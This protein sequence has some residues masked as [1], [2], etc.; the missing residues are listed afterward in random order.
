MITII[1]GTNRPNSKTFKVASICMKYFKSQGMSADIVDLSQ[2]HHDYL[3]NQMY[4]PKDDS[5]L[6]LVQDEKILPSD[7]LL[8]ISPE[9]NGSFPGVLKAFFDALSV[10]KYNETF[11]GRKVALLGVAAGRAGN[12]RGMEH[13]TGFLNYLN[14]LVMPNKLPISS[15]N[16]QFVNEN[17]LNDETMKTLSSFL[18][19]VVQFSLLGKGVFIE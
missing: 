8:I 15:I 1:S 12:L 9:Y 14:M 5:E 4:I 18:D 7:L 11:K 6:S 19:E 16:N 17:E 10:R 2:L 3:S 13:L